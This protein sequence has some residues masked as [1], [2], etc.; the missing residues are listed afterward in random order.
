MSKNRDRI[1]QSAL[2][3]F[4]ESDFD[5]VTIKD[6]C[7]K[8]RVANSTFYYHFKTKEDLMDC[9]RTHDLRPCRG[10]LF[11]LAAMHDLMERTL[12]AC[13]MCAARA[14]RSGWALTAQ[15]YKH[16]LNL[17]SE[18]DELHSLYAQE[19]RT[20][21]ELISH[22]QEE[23]LIL[24]QSSADELAMAANHLTS[25]V[26]VSWCVKKGGFDLMSTVCKNLLVLFNVKH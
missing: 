8:A 23:G 5:S 3:L 22:A 18:S 16:R 12:S 1:I 6:I 15:Y 14:Q 25:S 7:A 17:E 24:N 26:I 13:S 9:L 4:S 2:E 11:A 21:A 20:A 10:E 19:R